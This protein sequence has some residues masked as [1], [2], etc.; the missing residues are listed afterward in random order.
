MSNDVKRKVVRGISSGGYGGEPVVLDVNDEDKIVRIRP[1]D[2]RTSY[3]EE[4]LDDRLWKFEAR[5]KTFECSRRAAPPY[6]ALAYKNR[7]YSKNRVK[8]PLKRVD[9]EP[10]GDP[11]KI[12]AQNRGK[13]KFVRISWDEATQIIHDEIVRVHEKYGKS[14]ILAIGEDGHHENKWIHMTGGNHMRLL[15]YLGGYT[16]EVRT[17][18]SVEG[19]YWGAKHVWGDGLLSGLGAQN[20]YTNAVLD[21]SR[22]TGM[23]VLEAGDWE[24]TQS[25]CTQ[26]WSE[27]IKFWESVGI[28][29]VVIDPFCSYTAVCHDM[30]WIPILPNTD[31][32]LHFAI[33][34]VWLT[35]DLYD[36][37]YVA[38]HTVGS[39]KAFDYVLGKEDGIPKTPAWASEICGIPEWTIKALARKW[40]KVATSVGH[41]C[42]THVR[43]PYSHEIG[44]TEVYLLAMQ[45]VGKPGVEQLHMYSFTM[46]QE[47][48]N[49]LSF[50]WATGHAEQFMPNEYTI[51]RTLVHKAILDGKAE[52]WGTPQISFCPTED[53]FDKYQ[54][55]NP[56]P[57]DEDV[58]P[59]G[60]V[61]MIW[62]E[63]ASNQASWNGGF[64]L[65]EAFRSPK[66]ECFISNH[67]W[68]ENDSI[69]A[70]LVLPV[71]VCVEETDFSGSGENSQTIVHCCNDAIG[72][73]G[74]SLSDY[75]ISV[76]VAKKFGMEE[77]MNYGS[78]VEEDRRRAFDASIMP[79]EISYEEWKEKGYWIPRMQ[80]DWQDLPAGMSEFYEDPE[81]N[82]LSTP[83]GLI[84]F[85]SEALEENF[86]DDKER[87]PIAKWVIG[88]SKED[89]FMH[90]ESLWGEK[91]KMY[92][93]LLNTPPGRWR[94]HCQN[95]DIIWFR[96][97]DNCKVIGPD[98]YA[99]EPVWMSADEAA[100]RG[101]AEG[102][103]VKVFNDEGIILCGAHISE[104][105]PNGTVR[106]DKGAHADPIG[107]R[108]DRG[109][110]TNL[111][112]P[113][114]PISKYCVGFVVSGYLVQ[115]EK[116][117]DAE[118]E[119][120]K[121]EYPESFARAYDPASGSS[122]DG[123]VEGVE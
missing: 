73:C 21:V 48:M 5:G 74:E 87:A 69:F 113:P 106:I 55:P 44:R 120:W 100:K 57:E 53:Q 3:S 76:E 97:I 11:E 110:C 43:G 28:K 14:G 2:Y 116:L 104:R 98:G 91:A 7:V 103:I 82:E 51:P 67:Q 61:H 6:Y 22:N 86:P 93:L 41:F 90:D 35:E 115:V 71:S 47:S 81:D 89:G 102:D 40:G 27:V 85:Y 92:P 62:S 26:W 118:M 34:Y 122:Y 80:E 121:K 66:I 25:Y 31:N 60:E 68:L 42:G 58:E 123:W 117:Q 109:G 9:W 19:F 33:M 101:I 17:P 18:D 114:D 105:I 94:L 108:I 88:G 52:W 36:K 30:K 111:I 54:Y 79:T 38:T 56:E 84:E 64:L 13:S 4:Y 8:Y 77:Y 46:P 70:D 1:L 59:G 99:Y 107:P 75:E 83:S 112:S 65:E 10:G 63:K 49:C 119:Q 95:D 32:A 20:P 24:T 39:E 29:F 45:G 72:K 12:N 78:T 16:R 37:D 23:M 96:E 15:N 50:N